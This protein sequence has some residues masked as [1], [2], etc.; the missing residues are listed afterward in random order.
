MRMHARAG[1]GAGLA[2]A[3]GPASPSPKS[4]RPPTR[5]KARRSGRSTGR[6]G[7]APAPA[8]LLDRAPSPITFGPP[9]G[10]EDRRRPD[11]IE[12][13]A[14]VPHASAPR[15]VLGASPLRSHGVAGS[16]RIDDR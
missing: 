16:V 8:P 5:R 9:G 7:S 13:R 10:R 12:Y 6:G 14:A 11:S 2:A 1:D 4:P 15:P 3:D